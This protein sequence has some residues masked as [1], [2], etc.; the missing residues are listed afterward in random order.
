MR[1]RPSISASHQEACAR[2]AALFPS[3]WLRQYVGSKL[4]S[5]P[6]FPLAY[7]L[8]GNVT[9]PIL[10]VGCGVGLLAFYLR[11]RGVTQP[12]TGI[13]ID[14]RKVRRAAA[15]CRNNPELSGLQFIVHD[16]AHQLPAFR[17]NVVLFDLLHYLTPGAQQTLLHQ[18][19]RRVDS[20]ALLLLR[21]CPRDGS[22]RFRATYCAEVFAQTISWN[23]RAPL[24]FP[25]TESIDAALEQTEFSREIRPAWGAT[26]FNNQLFIYRRTRPEAVPATG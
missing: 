22:L 5:D 18:L 12:I 11:A 19:A 26:P 14:E 4:R 23:W 21:D 10:D 16:V 15:A 6:A 20:G 24:H 25:Q 2:V 17:G 3:R 8:L 13:D 7:E 9:E 1:D